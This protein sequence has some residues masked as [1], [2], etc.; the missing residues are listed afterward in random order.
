[1]RDGGTG[2][3]PESFI[4]IQDCAIVWIFHN[5]TSVLMPLNIKNQEVEGLVAQVAAFTGESK[6][7]SVLRP[8]ASVRRSWG[9]APRGSERWSWTLRRSSPPSSVIQAT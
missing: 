8:R 3:G 4:R 7:G 5:S 6:T 1:M 9:S 2:P